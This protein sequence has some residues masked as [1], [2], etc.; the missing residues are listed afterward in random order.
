MKEG[1][2]GGRKGGFHHSISYSVC[3]LCLLQVRVSCGV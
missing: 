2:K 1:G 3:I